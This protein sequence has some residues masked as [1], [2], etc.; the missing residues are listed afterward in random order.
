MKVT[1]CECVGPGWCERHQ[2][3]KSLELFRFCQLHPGTFQLW[4]EGRGPGQSVTRRHGKPRTVPCVHRRAALREEPCPTCRGS[5]RLKV[6]VCTLHGQCT[7]G[8]PLTG[9]AWC[10]TCVDYE[11]ESTAERKAPGTT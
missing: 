1:D 10:A 8:W 11:T 6:F 2:C 7:V 3:F 9:L 4:E 5:I